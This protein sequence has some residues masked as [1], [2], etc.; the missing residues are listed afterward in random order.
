MRTF[1]RAIYI[2]SFLD[3]WVLISKLADAEG[4]RK[5]R[6]GGVLISKL[7]DAESEGWADAH[8]LSS[9]PK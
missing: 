7:A 9:I 4:F 3:G 2:I 6:V 1:T 5:Y 8:R